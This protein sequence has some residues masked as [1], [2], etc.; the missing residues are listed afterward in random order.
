MGGGDRRLLARSTHAARAIGF[1]FLTGQ[2]LAVPSENVPDWSL[3]GVLLYWLGTTGLRANLDRALI[4]GKGV[5]DLRANQYYL[6]RI[7]NPDQD[8]N[9]R[10]RS[11]VGGFQSLFADVKAD[12][13]LTEFEKDSGMAAP[14]QTSYQST[15]ASGSDLN[16]I[17]KRSETMPTEAKMVARCKI[18]SWTYGAAYFPKAA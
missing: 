2:H 15:G 17:P 4:F 1:L 10:R 11:S 13:G 3:N 8:D 7:V 14:S 6:R 9:N 5:S 12:G 16:I 18:H